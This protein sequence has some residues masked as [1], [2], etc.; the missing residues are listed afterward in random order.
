[1]SEA[2]MVQG[3]GEIAYVVEGYFQFPSLQFLR[4]TPE[5]AYCRFVF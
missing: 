2:G 3:R 5:G 4:Y 1:M